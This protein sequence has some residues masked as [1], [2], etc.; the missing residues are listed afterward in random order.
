MKRTN[1][2]DIVQKHKR[3][4]LIIFVV[5]IVLVVTIVTTIMLGSKEEN[6]GITTISEASL[7]EVIEVS[8]LST[9]EYTYNS[10][11]FKANKKEVEYYVAYK[12]TVQLGF[13]FSQLT[14][15]TD[16]EAKK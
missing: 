14:V 2:L 5:V 16:H 8:E 10:H 11:T 1:L 6:K 15:N 4:L 13:D 7:K 9:L 12:G 3:L